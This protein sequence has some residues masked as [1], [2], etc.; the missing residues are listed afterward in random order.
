MTVTLANA[1]SFIG[2]DSTVL[3]DA[4]LQMDLDVAI[5]YCTGY[6]NAKGAPPSGPAFDSAVQY[7]TLINVRQ[8]L[9][10]MGI[11]PESFAS[12]GITM[13]TNLSSNVTV[14]DAMVQKYLVAAVLAFGNRDQ[15]I[16][17]IRSG[18]TSGRM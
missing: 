7:S 12:A 15:Y 11:K 1:R 17:H 16:R 6:M 5:N 18:K 3:P 2:I 13:S 14:L 10:I 9:D 8:T 4:N